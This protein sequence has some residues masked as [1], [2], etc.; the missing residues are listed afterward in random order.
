MGLR[1][2]GNRLETGTKHPGNRR[3]AARTGR[4]AVRKVL[5][6]HNVALSST[7][8]H[9][10]SFHPFEEALLVIQPA[11]GD[12]QRGS[13]LTS[14]RA[15]DH[16]PDLAERSSPSGVIRR[17]ESDACDGGIPGTAAVQHERER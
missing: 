3:F 11:C 13:E 12:P 5:T 4:I 8:W 10:A 14:T 7:T 15:A 1:A 6:T 16:V 2:V 17:F 9:A